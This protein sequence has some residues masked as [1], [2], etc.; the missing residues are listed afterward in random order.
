MK[1]CLMINSIIR[2]F[3]SIFC[4]HDYK[5]VSEYFYLNANTQKFHVYQCEKCDCVEII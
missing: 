2:F 5:V 4:D 1:D 3:I